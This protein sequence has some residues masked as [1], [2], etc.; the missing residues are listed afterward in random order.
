MFRIHKNMHQK[1]FYLQLILF[2]KNLKYI[3][4]K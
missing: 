4:I 3:G 2:I 1:F